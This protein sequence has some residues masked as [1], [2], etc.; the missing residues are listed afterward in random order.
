VKSIYTVLPSVESVSF[1]L[2]PALHH[3]TQK[4]SK[5]SLLLA[6][7]NNSIAINMQK[8]INLIL[9]AFAMSVNGISL[10]QNLPNGLFSVTP[11]S[12]GVPQFIQLLEYKDGE[13][14]RPEDAPKAALDYSTS[15][16]KRQTGQGCT[17]GVMPLSDYEA[18]RQCMI[19]FG[20]NGGSAAPSSTVFCR[21]GQ[22]VLAMC[23][24]YDWQSTTIH[25]TDI[26]TMDTYVGSSCRGADTTGYLHWTIGNMTYWRDLLGKPICCDM[27][28]GLYCKK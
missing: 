18:A 4:Y 14:P 9:A 6:T 22:A 5:D 7:D 3:N 16:D 8:K 20:N 11:D 13:Y 23:N 28:G 26:V 10:P 1:C 2:D 21:Y 12:N 15:V 19:T 25:S 27:P 17:G 24:Y